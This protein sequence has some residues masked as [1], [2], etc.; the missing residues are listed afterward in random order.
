[1]YVFLFDQKTAYKMRNSDWSSDVC[2]SDLARQHRR[3]FLGEQRARAI[4]Q[5]VDPFELVVEFG[6]GLRIAVGQIDRRDR[7]PVDIDL[8]I[9]AVRILGIAREPALALDRTHALG[10]HPAP[11]TAPQRRVR[12]GCGWKIETE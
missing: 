6:A 3:A 2:P 8:E 9:A 12:R 1:M 5:P 10:E 7:Q 11:L 4:A